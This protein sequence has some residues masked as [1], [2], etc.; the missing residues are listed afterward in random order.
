MC[1]QKPNMTSSNVLFQPQ[2]KDGKFTD[3]RGAKKQ[4]I[5]TFS[6][7]ESDFF[8]LKKGLKSS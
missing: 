7:L 4:K 3:N 1:L 8:V 6:Q 5:F 2:P